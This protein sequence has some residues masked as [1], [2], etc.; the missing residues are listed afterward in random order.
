MPAPAGLHQLIDQCTHMRRA[1]ETAGAPLARTREDGFQSLLR[2]IVD[3]QVSTHAG[4]A[5]W[6]KLGTVLGDVTPES[7]L[8]ADEDTLRSG[9]L[10]RAK[11]RY[12]KAL[13][14]EI[15]SGRLDLIALRK[16][17]DAD[18]MEQLT[19]VKGIGRWTAEIYLMFALGRPDVFPVGDLALLVAAGR[20][21]GLEERPSQKEM[22]EIAE[23]WRPWRSTAALMLWH[24]YRFSGGTGAPGEG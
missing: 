21:L 7:V 5:I 6:R 4:A 10:S 19:A 24:Y 16:A 23:T 17:S 15:V 3:Q 2:T 20:L 9:G 22:E 13:A 11:A 14:D 18:V 12:G 8:A 1:Y